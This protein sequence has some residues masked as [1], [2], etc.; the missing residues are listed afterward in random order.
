MKNLHSIKG[1]LACPDCHSLLSSVDGKLRCGPCSRDFPIINDVPVLFSQKDETIVHEGQEAYSEHDSSSLKNRLKR[2]LPLPNF[3]L[4]RPTLHDRL[5]DAHIFNASAEAMILNLGSGVQNE[6]SHPGLINFDIYPH[7]NTDVAGD[8]HQLPFI[9]S[10][11]DGVWLCAV[12][13]HLNRPFAVGNEVCRVLKPGGFVLVTVPFIY[14]HHGAPHD[15]FRYTLDGLRSV[16]S[17]LHEIEGGATGAGPFG[18][19]AQMT[20]VLAGGFSRKALLSYALRFTT[21]WALYPFAFLDKL[22]KDKFAGSPV[23]GGVCYMGRK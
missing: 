5:R 18:T 11:L 21:G 4:A 13:E 6:L 17:N 20:M 2:F 10:C 19:W 23:C 16:F 3:I 7:G 14:P 15:F 12:M 8:A 1:I 22:M 9:D